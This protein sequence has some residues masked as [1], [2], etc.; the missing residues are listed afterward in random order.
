MARLSV[1]AIAS[2]MLL[3]LLAIVPA[4]VVASGGQFGPYRVT[5]VGS[6]P[7]AVAIGDVTGDGIADIV[8]TTGYANTPADFELFV[9]AGKA[10]GTLAAPVTYAT[11]GTYG[12]RP[13]TVDIGDVNGDGRPDV[14]VGLSGLGIQVF[15]QAGDG[16]LGTPT[17]TTSI[18]SHKVAVLDTPAGTEVAGIGWGTDTVTIFADTGAGLSATATYP[19]QHGGWDDIEAGDVTGDGRPDIV[20]M[21]G[22]GF[23]PNV[24]V[25]PALGDGTF[26]PV[27]EYSVGG[28]QLTQG[29]GVGDV[30]G[31]GRSDVVASYG[32]NSPTG[33]LGVFA[34][35]PAGH[36]RGA[37][38][39]VPELRHSRR[40]RGLGRRP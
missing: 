29:I 8:L 1:L 37:P 40:G 28:N 12:Q 33:R 27:A 6:A 24:S 4:S 39:R 3:A 16:T 10:D 21:S 19:V 31:D 9:F 17:L 18:D 11:A 26:G 20:V 36:A 5:P 23:V 35:S 15:A 7:E 2:A 25:L 38:D 30:T 14:V 22:Q 34:Q 13:A 32:G